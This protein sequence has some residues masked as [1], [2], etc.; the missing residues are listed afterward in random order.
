MI[1]AMSHTPVYRTYLLPCPANPGKVEAIAAWVTRW[2]ELATLE[3]DYQIAHFR[4]TGGKQGLHNKV[5]QGWTRPW[6]QDGRCSVTMAQ[7]IMSQVCAQ[8]KGHVEILKNAVQALI[9]EQA[10]DPDNAWDANERH[11]L[12]SINRHGLW[13]ARGGVKSPIAGETCIPKGSVRVAC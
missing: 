3:R 5:E 6:V 2:R 1:S 10:R 13:W 8:L 12:Y 9:G 4:K 7:Q 11:R